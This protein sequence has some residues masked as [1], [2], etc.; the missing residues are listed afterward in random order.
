M[1]AALPVVIVKTGIEKAIFVGKF[2]V[3][4]CSGGF[5]FPN[6]LVEN[7]VYEVYPH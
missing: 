3:F 5:I 2:C 7:D 6:I 4:L 1:D